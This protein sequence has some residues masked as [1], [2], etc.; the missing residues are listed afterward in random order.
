MS[1]NP[2]SSPHPHLPLSGACRTG[3]WSIW[4]FC[5]PQSSSPCMHQSA[6]FLLLGHWTP[7]NSWDWAPLFSM[8]LLSS[9]SIISTMESSSSVKWISEFG[10][11]E[12]RFP[13]PHHQAILCLDPSHEVLLVQNLLGTGL[14]LLCLLPRKYA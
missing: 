6:R 3:L 2:L 1:R 9:S 13:P 4:P 14:H 5:V 10:V 7:T 12:V 8:Q 11:F